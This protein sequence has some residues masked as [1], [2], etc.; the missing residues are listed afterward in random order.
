LSWID[1]LGT[2][3]GILTTFSAAPQLVTSYRTRNVRDLDLR[4]LL[5]LDV[6]LFL[7]A[8]YG[9]AIMSLPIIVF[10]AIG[11]LLWLP[12]IWMKIANR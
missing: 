2:L 7:W 1:I 9:I 8:L 10:N 4:F 5:M 12:I 6:G 11:C 3:A